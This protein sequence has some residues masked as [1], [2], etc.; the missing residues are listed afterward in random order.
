MA[1]EQAK[2][3]GLKETGAVRG[4]KEGK[5][6]FAAGSVGRSPSPDNWWL[7]GCKIDAITKVEE[8]IDHH[9]TPRRV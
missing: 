1:R 5:R 9:S 6:F 8:I 4:R 7:P 2:Y 3:V